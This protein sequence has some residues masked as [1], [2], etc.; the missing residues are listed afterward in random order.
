MHQIEIIILKVIA[1]SS[2]LP[3]TV[4]PSRK[5]NILVLVFYIPFL[6]FS[7]ENSIPFLLIHNENK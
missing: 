7:L 2:F 4:F 6:W 5:I 1:K 3:S